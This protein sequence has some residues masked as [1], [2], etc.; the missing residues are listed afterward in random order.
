[1]IE[2]IF[3]TLFLKP[4]VNLLVFIYRSIDSA[5]IPYAFGFAI[6]SL[7]IIV[8]LI[9]WPFINSQ[10]KHSRKMADLK[11]E[12]DE[13]KKKH[14]GD[15]IAFAQAQSSLFKEKG[16]NPASGCLPS[17]IQLPVIFALFQSISSFF[18]PGG[19]ERIN[20]LLYSISWHFQSIPNL[21]FFGIDLTIKPSAFTEGYFLLLLI[22]ITTA[23]LQ[24]IQSK[25]M[26]PAQPIKEY[27]T[28][29]K[30]EKEEKESFEDSMSMMQSQMIYMMPLM[31]GIFA[32]QFPIGIALY[33]NVFSLLGIYQQHRVSG[34]GS[35]PALL[36]SINKTIATRS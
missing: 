5:G 27:P 31:V 18:N 2:E 36:T 3:N 16:V 1:M 30:K 26:M 25:M 9:V 4:V 19:L 24:F 21:N 13:L 8:R 7:S 29:S 10:L 28:D 17:L 22:P 6:I 33:W 12:L 32:F 34:W 20:S 11:P 15:K 35:L 23:L 14:K